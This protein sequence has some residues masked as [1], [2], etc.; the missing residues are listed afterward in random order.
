M[1]EQKKTFPRKRPLNGIGLLS[2]VALL[3]S[4]YVFWTTA[5]GSNLAGCGEGSSCEEVLQT[6]WSSVL[7]LPVSLGAVFVYAAILV[8]SRRLA[9][10]D[11]LLSWRVLLFLG[12]LAAGSGLWFLGL[13]LFLIHSLCYFC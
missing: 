4:A 2:L 3:L 8:T 7:G 9:R 11:S 6:Q 13:Q 10:M 5:R 12:T 1:K